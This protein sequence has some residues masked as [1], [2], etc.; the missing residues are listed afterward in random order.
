MSLKNR[1]DWA[2]VQARSKAGFAPTI[3]RYKSRIDASERS[4][5]RVETEL[6]AV[7]ERVEI[8]QAQSYAH[9]D[10]CKRLYGVLTKSTARLLDETPESQAF[11]RKT[12]AV[13]NLGHAGFFLSGF[14]DL[15]DK[16]NAQIEVYSSALAMSKEL[17][18]E[19]RSIIE[20]FETRALSQKSR[21]A[22][23]VEVR[24]LYEFFERGSV[25]LKKCAMGFCGAANTVF[26]GLPERFDGIVKALE[27]IKHDIPASA[28]TE[29]VDTRLN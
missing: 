27:E 3:E 13:L 9:L 8:F 6:A 20:E 14:S 23:M 16:M 28:H 7:M 11:L 15:G 1:R 24:T 18:A 19:L 4:M 21:S 22:A 25:N 10:A 26:E 17:I 5:A 2:H 12:G 29:A